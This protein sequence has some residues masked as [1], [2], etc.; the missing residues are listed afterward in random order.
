MI[1]NTG[2]WEV[3]LFLTDVNRRF[4][5]NQLNLIATVVTDICSYLPPDA[6]AGAVYLAALPYIGPIMGK[7][8]TST[9]MGFLPGLIC[10]DSVPTSVKTILDFADSLFIDPS[11]VSW[12][13]K[14]LWI[15]M[16]A[17]QTPNDRKLILTRPQDPTKL[18]E[19]AAE[20]LPLLIV[21]GSSDNQVRGDVLVE[22]I[23]PRFKNVDVVTIE[24]NGSH[25]MLFENEKEVM[26]S[27]IAFAKRVEAT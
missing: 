26:S 23:K 6:I 20:G 4:G 7:V 9:I 16:A 1:S 21:N 13:T 8:G 15:G 11:A 19:R 27:I 24:K 5:L 2:A 22:E 10:E 17:C 12:E 3:R 14:A 25:A 18:F